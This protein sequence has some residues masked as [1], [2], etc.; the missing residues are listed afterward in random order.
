MAK[1]QHYRVDFTN[2]LNNKKG[3]DRKSYEFTYQLY[4]VNKYIYIYN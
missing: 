1:R 3:G 2:S 4:Q